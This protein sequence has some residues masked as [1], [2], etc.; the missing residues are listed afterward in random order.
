MIGQLAITTGRFGLLALDFLI[1]FFAKG[2]L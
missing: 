1:L 2:T